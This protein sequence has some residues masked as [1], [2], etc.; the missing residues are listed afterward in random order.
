MALLALIIASL[1]FAMSGIFNRMISVDAGAFTGMLARTLLPMLFFGLASIVNNNKI[2]IT[3][4]KSLGFF[5]FRGFIVVIDVVTF[6]LAVTRLELGLALL[7]FYVSFLAISFLTSV[8]IFK[9]KIKQID[10]IALLIAILGL[11]IIYFNTSNQIDLFGVICI[12]VCGICYGLNITSSKHL[13]NKYSILTINTVTYTIATVIAFPVFLFALQTGNEK[14]NLT[15]GLE[16]IAGIFLIGFTTFLTFYLVIF[17]FKKLDVNKASLI[18][19]S[20]IIFTFILGMI[21]YNEQPK[22]NTIIGGCLI[23]IAL[24]LPYIKINYFLKRSNE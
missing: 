3:D 17:G 19:L 18:M 11:F 12:V 5:V 8:F 10:I 20:E 23:I 14:I 24:A 13:S 15:L 7:L 16:S 6:F 1:L 4:K 22:I 21:L 9:E 2:K